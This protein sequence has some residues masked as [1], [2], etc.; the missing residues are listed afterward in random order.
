M[1]T[2]GEKMVLDLLGRSSLLL[3]LVLWGPVHLLC[4][5]PKNFTRAQ[6]FEVQH[7]QLSPL[8]CNRAMSG[9]NK[10]TQHCKPEN[11]FLHDSFEDV[12]ATCDLPNTICK[13]GRNNCHRSPK[14]INMTQCSLTAGR[15]PDCR[16]KDANIFKFFI[17][18]CDPPEKGDPPYRLVPVHLDK[19]V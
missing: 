11:T 4:A 12:A 8:Q 15:Y 1:N 19:I 18:A 14:P 16:Y 6:W 13:N 2:S 10:Y 17:V 9:V 5:W 3:L 7:I